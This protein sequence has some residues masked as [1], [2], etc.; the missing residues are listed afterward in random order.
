MIIWVFGG[1]NDKYCCTQ[2]Q[3]GVEKGQQL[4]LHVFKYFTSLYS[5]G[6]LLIDPIL[7]NA[8]RGLHFY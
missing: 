8:I 3:D 4:G 7:G 2:D 6:G 5:G 1:I